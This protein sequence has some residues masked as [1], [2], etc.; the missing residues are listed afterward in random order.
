MSAKNDSQRRTISVIEWKMSK[1]FEESFTG[2]VV[3][4]VSYNQGG[5]A[6]VQLTE[7]SEIQFNEKKP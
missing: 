3:F 7:T 6:R 5:V 2:Q 4:T 1:L